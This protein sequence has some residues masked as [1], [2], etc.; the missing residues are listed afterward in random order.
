MAIVILILKILGIVL[1]SILGLIILLILALLFCNIRYRIGLVYEDDASA[2][3][4]VSWLGPLIVFIGS[5]IEGGFRAR[6]R[7][8][9]ITKKLSGYEQEI[10]E[11]ER[12]SNE[13]VNEQSESLPHEDRSEGTEECEDVLEKRTIGSKADLNDL[14][15]NSDKELRAKRSGDK[16]LEHE[17][18]TNENLADEEFTDKEFDE[19]FEEHEKASQQKQKSRVSDKINSIKSKINDENNRAAVSKLWG[20]L[21]ALLNHYGPRKIEGYLRYSLSDP[22]WTGKILGILALFPINYKYGYTIEPDFV[23]EDMYAKGNVSVKGRI[24]LWYIVLS[25]IK[26]IRDADIKRLIKKI[27]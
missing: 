11:P 9:G 15:S 7:I 8:F 2:E 5:Y 19:A 25:G 4:R 18:L 14:E 21:K 13:T 6:V 23:S 26:A 1:L 24:M 20:M 16:A 27:R 12:A 22:A 3:I 17:S 10:K